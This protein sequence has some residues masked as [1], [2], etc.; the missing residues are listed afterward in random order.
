MARASSFPVLSFMSTHA[1]VTRVVG[2]RRRPGPRT[3]C[4][5]SR[6]QPTDHTL[7]QTASLGPDPRTADLDM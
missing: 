6:G 1:R 3:E 2:T 7:G 5:R 4:E